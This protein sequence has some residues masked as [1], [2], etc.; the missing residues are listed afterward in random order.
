L[1]VNDALFG[2][3][4]K[5]RGMPKIV[6]VIAVVAFAS[7]AGFVLLDRASRQPPPGPP[8]LTADAREYVKHLG[9][10]GVDMQAHMNFLNQQ[11]VELTGNI[12]NNGDRKLSLVEVNCIFYDQGYD[13]DR[14]V[15]LRDRVPIV[16]RAM[17]GLAPG[18]TKSFRLPFDSIPEGWNQVQPQMVIAQIQFQ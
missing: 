1:L 3:Q 11:T 2:A 18:E 9:L 15:I 6:Y 4:P 14:K 10:S 5:K 16:S 7:A 12:T 13:S 17:G 8:S